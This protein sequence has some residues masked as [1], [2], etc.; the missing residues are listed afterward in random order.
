ML[1]SNWKVE[2]TSL[3]FVSNHM[4]INFNVVL[5]VHK[6]RNWLLYERQ[7]ECHRNLH[8]GCE[9]LEGGIKS[10][11]LTGCLYKSLVLYFRRSTLR[12][13]YYLLA[14]YFSTKSRN[15]RER[16]NEE[17]EWRQVARSKSQNHLRLGEDEARK[18]NP[19]HGFVLMNLRTRIAA[20]R[21]TSMEH[22]NKCPSFPATYDISKANGWNMA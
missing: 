19:R 3:N 13:W 5:S 2:D 21:C 4:T 17:D 6:I 7:I 8:V 15:F 11:C 20:L 1:G 12:A 14:S 10:M 18:N 22:T 16:N 9:S